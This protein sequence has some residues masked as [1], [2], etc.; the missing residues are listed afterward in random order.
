MVSKHGI[1]LY[2]YQAQCNSDMTAWAA[3]Q[4]HS[5]I[6]THLQR[7]QQSGWT[8]WSM[9]RWGWFEINR[10]TVMLLPMILALYK[11]LAGS[12]GQGVWIRPLSHKNR[13]PSATSLHNAL[14][15]GAIYTLTQTRP[16]LMLLHL[17]LWLDQSRIRCLRLTSP[18]ELDVCSHDHP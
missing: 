11:S 17:Y 9:H 14:A 7:V 15:F 8:F 13:V 5:W 2:L 16:T 3:F 12:L 4:T 6:F 18:L 10:Q 1:C